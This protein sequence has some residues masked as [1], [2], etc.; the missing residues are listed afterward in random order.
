MSQLKQAQKI[1]VGMH[2]GRPGFTIEYTD[3]ER[4]HF[5]F[6]KQVAKTLA[7]SLLKLIAD[8]EYV[9]RQLAGAPNDRI[10]LSEHVSVKLTPPAL[11]LN[12]GDGIG[13]SD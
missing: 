9:D 13:V 8:L 6:G 12:G 3:G 2:D 4:G 11:G 10:G 1:E 5:I 7:E